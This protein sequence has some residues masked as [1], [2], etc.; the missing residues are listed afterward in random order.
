ML[1]FDGVCERICRAELVECYEVMFF[2]FPKHHLTNRQL[3]ERLVFPME[4]TMPSMLAQTLLLTVTSLQSP[5]SPTYRMWLLTT[6]GC[7]LKTRHNMVWIFGASC[8]KTTHFLFRVLF[9]SEPMK[10][11]ARSHRDCVPHGAFLV[12]SGGYIP[13]E[14]YN[15]QTRGDHRVLLAKKRL[16][17]ASTFDCIHIDGTNKTVCKLHNRNELVSLEKLKAE[18]GEVY[19]E[20]L[21]WHWPDQCG[22]SPTSRHFTRQSVWFVL[23]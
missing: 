14:W 18:N 11:S 10:R 3:V 13:F 23:S 7:R 12:W 2:T 8:V 4:F 9:R 17:R 15:Y 19:R 22:L 6:M 16:Q 20:F 21:P 1:I 5:Q